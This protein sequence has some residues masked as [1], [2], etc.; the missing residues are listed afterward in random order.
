MIK[1]SLEC[2][3]CSLLFNSWF[4]SSKEYERL[5]KK[6]LLNCLECN[7]SSV[8]KTLM[9]PKII[10]KSDKINIKNYKDIKNTIIKYQKFI[11]E[12]FSYVGKNFAFEARSIHY[13]DKKGKKGIYGTASNN[14]IR[15]LRDEGINA[16]IIPWV[17]DKNN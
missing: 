9:A 17:K 4:S 13:D 8:E 7:S 5:K 6:K 1:Y 12:N 3:K 11:K 2:K 16:E 15:E 10:V 14:E